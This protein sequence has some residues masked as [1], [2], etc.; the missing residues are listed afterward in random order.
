MET[1]R[2]HADFNDLPGPGDTD[3]RMWL[4]YWGSLCDLARQHVRLRS[5]MR[6]TLYDSSDGEED[7]EVDG[8]AKYDP[9][10]TDPHFNWFVEVRQETFRRVPHVPSAHRAVLMCFEC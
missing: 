5:G 6:I 3:Q 4:S 7:M 8:V 9:S 1:P 10:S 2:V